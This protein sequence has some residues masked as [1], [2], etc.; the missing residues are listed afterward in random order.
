MMDDGVR[1]GKP[2]TKFEGAPGVT[3]DEVVS[4]NTAGAEKVYMNVLPTPPGAKAKPHYHKGIETIAYMLKGEC[5][6]FHCEKLES[7]TSFKQGE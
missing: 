6:V 7:Q 1:L 3:Y 2:G 5:R 4:S